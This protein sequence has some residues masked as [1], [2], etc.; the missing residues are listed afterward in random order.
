[1]KNLSFSLIVAILCVTISSAQSTDAFKYQAMIRDANG[2]I[3]HSLNTTIQVKIKEGSASGETKYAE[4]HP[5]VSVERGLFSISIGE[6]QNMQ[7]KIADLDFGKKNYFLEVGVKLPSS[8]AIEVLPATQIFGTTKAIFANRADMANHAIAAD[9][10]TFADRAKVAESSE[11][12][13]RAG[14]SSIISRVN[15]VT[16]GGSSNDAILDVKGITTTNCLEIRGG[17][18]LTEGFDITTKNNTEIEPG[19]LVSIDPHTPGK[20]IVTT[21]AYDKKLAG[22]ISGA[23]GI[24]PGV[25]MGQKGSIADGDYPV[26]LTGRVYVKADASFG[27]IKSGDIL[28]SSPISG[29]AM[30]VKKYARAQGAIVGKAMSDLE[31]GQGYVLVL[32]N[33]H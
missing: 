30:K 24:N 9:R 18:D 26:A 21:E 16:I 12:W 19:T 6:G 17:C 22:I 29:F 5:N 2:N 27:S 3:F 14:N 13:I 8:A 23:N 20:L 31:I 4:N 33:L 15:N 10:A 25:M 11:D 7:G 28:T 1:M 32:V